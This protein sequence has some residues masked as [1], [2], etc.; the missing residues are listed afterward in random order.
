MNNF[1][2][3]DYDADSKLV[4]GILKQKFYQVLDDITRFLPDGRSRAMVITHLEE[5]MMWIGKAIRDK[6]IMAELA[7]KDKP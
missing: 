3:V 2:T 4:A 5:A 6:Q 7:A 1:D